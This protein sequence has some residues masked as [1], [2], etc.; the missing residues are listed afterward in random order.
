[1][2][3]NF[4]ISM[5]ARNAVVD[6]VAALFE[7]AGP[8]APTLEILSGAAPASLTDP[9][10]GTSFAVIGWPI[11]SVLFNAAAGGSAEVGPTELATTACEVPGT[12]G[13]FRMYDRNSVAILQG[14]CGDATDTPVDL[15]FTIKTFTAG[16]T[17]AVDSITLTMPE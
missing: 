1:M 15:E 9:A 5:A 14:S 13:Y 10:S 11:G 17:F 6:A 12:V 16:V 8:A 2:A 7:V 3:S 4:K